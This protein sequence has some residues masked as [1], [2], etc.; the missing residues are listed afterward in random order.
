MMKKMMMRAL[1][2]VLAMSLV[3]CGE[4][5]RMADAQQQITLSADVTM[6]TKDEN[7]TE[8]TVGG[9]TVVEK[10]TNQK[11][12]VASGLFSLTYEGVKITPNEA[13]D[14]AALPEA[15][16]L[17]TVPSC[18]LEGTDNVYNYG[19]FEVTAY[20]EGKGEFVYSV[21]FIDP[22][23]TTDE[24][25]ALGDD[26]SRVLELYGDGYT[27]ESGT[28]VYTRSGTQLRLIV[29]NDSVVSIEYR[30]AT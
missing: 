14:A 3:A 2:L 4:E 17:Y 23:M 27:E 15:Q 13:F 16:S 29:E 11:P 12:V 24:G 30:M 18:A 26:L 9:E 7:A 10:P 5:D 28:Y 25:L 22:N 20:D 19:A 21:Y 6:A 1:L 8:A